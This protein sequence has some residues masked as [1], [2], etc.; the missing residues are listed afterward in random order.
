MTLNSVCGFLFLFFNVW[1]EILPWHRLH[2]TGLLVSHGTSSWIWPGE[3]PWRRTWTLQLKE[4]QAQKLRFVATGVEE[5][6]SSHLLPN[7]FCHLM[8]RANSLEKTLMLGKTEGRRRSGWQRMRWLDGI[9]DSV[10]MSLRK[11]RE[12][13]KHREAWRAA[14]CGSI[15][16]RHNWAT[17]Q[18][19]SDPPTKSGIQQGRASNRDGSKSGPAGTGWGCLSSK[20]PLERIK[21]WDLNEIKDS[22]QMQK[23]DVQI[24]MNKYLTVATDWMFPPLTQNPH[25]EI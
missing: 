15:R 7:Y 11:L 19:R 12:M 14:V 13:V 3:V 18:H 21:F 1:W 25:V 24:L 16:V 8:W 10:D 22:L 2:Y 17:G 20:G 4:I 23:E 5:Q 6:M 9:T